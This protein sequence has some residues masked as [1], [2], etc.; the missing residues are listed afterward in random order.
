MLPHSRE[1]QRPFWFLRDFW[2]A[3]EVDPSVWAYMTRDPDLVLWLAER[4]DHGSEGDE[5]WAPLSA[6]KIEMILTTYLPHWPPVLLPS[7]WGT[8]S[9]KGETAYRYLSAIV[10]QIGRD[11]PSIALPVAD[12]LLALEITAPSHNVLRSI[13]SDLRRKAALTSARPGAS[14][15]AAALD[16]GPPASVEQL[17]AQVMELLAEMQKDVRHGDKGVVHQFYNGDDRLDEVSAMYRVSAWL[18]PRLT[19]FDIHEVVEHQLGDRNRCDLTATRMVGGRSRMLVIEGKGQWHRD[20][21][22]AARLQLS[23]R[24]AMHPD[25]DEQ[26]IFLVIWYGPDEEVAGRK[27]HGYGS[28]AG[29]CA[30]IRDQLPEELRGR[31]DV[32]VLDVART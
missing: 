18:A 10:W 29:L 26:G 2:F 7:M 8:G 3:R 14:E 31:V 1:A 24:Y 22:T 21:F 17:R 28:A 13:R 30:A 5:V 16:G 19:P 20:L 6:P 4:R 27:Q 25:A 23:E 15:I 9:P 32:F 12:R 11:A